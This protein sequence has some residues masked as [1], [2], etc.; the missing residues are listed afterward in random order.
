MLSGTLTLCYQIPLWSTLRPTHTQLY[1]ISS[2]YPL[3]P[4]LLS[5]H[6]LVTTISNVTAQTPGGLNP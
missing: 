5:R 4:Q 6:C 2:L 3:K 1:N